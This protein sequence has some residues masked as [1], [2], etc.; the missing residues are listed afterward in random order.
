MNYLGSAEW[1]RG[2]TLIV[3]SGGCWKRREKD[4]I[5]GREERICIFIF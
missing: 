4:T 1:K 2:V 5:S 3:V